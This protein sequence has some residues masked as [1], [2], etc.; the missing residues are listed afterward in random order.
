[1]RATL[2]Y[3]PG[4]I[5]VETV[6]DPTIEAATDAIVRVV[7][8]CICGSDLWYYR[9]ESDFEIGGPIGHEFIGVVE[10]VGAAV[11]SL[12]VGQMV[13][14]PWAFS[15][16][17]CEFCRAGLQTSCVVGGYWG[18]DQ[19][20]GQA[21]LV[22][23]PLAD[24]T[25]VAVL[26][27]VTDDAMLASLL[28]LSD[29]M[30]TGHHAT[31]LA[32]TV[33]GG[34]TVVIGDGA[35]GLCAVLAAKRSGAERIV[36]VGRHQNRLEL[37]RRFGATDLVTDNRDPNETLAEVLDLTDGGAASVCECVGYSAAVDL[38][39]DCARPGG[40]V[41]FVGVPHLDGGVDISRAFSHNIALRFGL[42]PIRH[43]LPELLADVL[44]G[45]I[46]P[47]PVFDFEV[48]MADVPAGYAAMRDRRAIKT[49]IKPE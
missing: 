18:G 43:Y 45:T 21:E 12:R 6:P 42:A 9:G 40:S 13:V 28:T 31:V 49:I 35:V 2:F 10:E 7:R 34:T 32:E 29:V 14:A 23:V 25:L 4:D 3:G 8:S 44:D 11:T 36:A 48:S 38:A 30:G 33:K 37:A 39:I 15:C 5:R 26:G 19:C 20:G 22:R 16:G 47:S 24:G 1:M 27:E 41:G 17:D 46:D